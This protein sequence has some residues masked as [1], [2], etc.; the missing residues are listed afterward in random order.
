MSRSV[1]RAVAHATLVGVLAVAL[2]SSA[3]YAQVDMPLPGVAGTYETASLS[4]WLGVPRVTNPQNIRLVVAGTQIPGAILTS[5]G[6]AWDT[7]IEVHFMLRLGGSL[8][9]LAFHGWLP[10]IDGDIVAELPCD[11]RLP[12]GWAPGPSE[13]IMHLGHDPNFSPVSWWYYP[14][15]VVTIVTARLVA[16]QA[17][18]SE[19]QAWGTVKSLFR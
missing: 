18:P 16:D 9:W 5:W 1:V 10:P 4:G 14:R 11:L 2:L 13:F 19:S 15:P 12:G 8:E 7:G 6:D 3:S 17:V